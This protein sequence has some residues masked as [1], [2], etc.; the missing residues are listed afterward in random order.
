MGD[1]R[2]LLPLAAVMIAVGGCG[3]DGDE[4]RPAA[5]EPAATTSA[6]PAPPGTSTTTATEGP[7]RKPS[8][9]RTPRSLAACLRTAPGV[10]EVLVKG[11][12][13]DD[14][15]FFSDLA[16]GRVDVLGVTVEG[17]AGEVTVAVYESAAAAKKAAPNA[18]GGSTVAIKAVGSALVIAPLRAPTAAV[19]DCLSAAGY[20]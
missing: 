15:M 4:R 1:V 16:E 2:R 7:E 11:R 12:D 3:G 17:A 8:Y 20:E 10:D 6:R 18:G 5:P 14:V 13:S 9:E 19:E